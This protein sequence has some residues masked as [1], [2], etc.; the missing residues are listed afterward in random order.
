M[1]WVYITWRAQTPGCCQT[2]QFER[3]ATAVSCWRDQLLMAE[4]RG[5]S[6]G[7]RA[8]SA[9]FRSV[10]S[11]MSAVGSSRPYPKHS[12]YE[13]IFSLIYQSM[14]WMPHCMLTA[15][16][17]DC[18]ERGVSFLSHNPS[19][20]PQKLTTVHLHVRVCITFYLQ[21]VARIQEDLS[22]TTTSWLP[23]ISK[24]HPANKCASYRN[25]KTQ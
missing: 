7:V 21:D 22:T 25:K 13:Q 14:F 16:V 3:C 23:V 20:F 18:N 9:L 12:E 2:H 11:R 5:T 8:A 17:W 19:F 6:P 1:R 4:G 24:P 10:R 15:G